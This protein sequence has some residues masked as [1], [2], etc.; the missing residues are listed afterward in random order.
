[1]PTMPPTAKIRR[2]TMV[3]EMQGM[4]MWMACFIREAP[5][6]TADS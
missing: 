1:M 5:S 3:E 2:I 4:V 6:R